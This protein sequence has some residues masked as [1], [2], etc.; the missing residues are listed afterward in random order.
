MKY[1]SK[2]ALSV[3]RYLESMTET[4]NKKIINTG[5]NSNK[6]GLLVYQSTYFQ[7]SQMIELIER[8][9]KFINLK[10]AVE[11]TLATLSN[12]DRRILV[13]AYI[14]GVTSVIIAQLLNVSLR[15]YFRK[16]A[17]A[18]ER[19][20]DRMD[21]FGLNEKFFASEYG[22]EMWFMGVYNDILSAG[23]TDDALEKPTIHRMFSQISKV[24]PIWIKCYQYFLTSLF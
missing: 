13:L 10:V 2:T 6:E 19:F 11:E 12:I 21:K 9:R 8:K 18:I 7:T 1:W 14:D 24:N 4:V 15:T 22:D 16:K 23:I 17:A 5:S 20:A 3:Y